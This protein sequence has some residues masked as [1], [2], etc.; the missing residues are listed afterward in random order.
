[1][2][3]E[4]DD[5]GGGAVQLGAELLGRDAALDDDRALRNGSVP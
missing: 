1:L 3:Q 2:E 5:V 4:L